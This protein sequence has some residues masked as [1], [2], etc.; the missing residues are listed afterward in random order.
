MKDISSSIN[1]ILYFTKY[2]KAKHT[3]KSNNR[4]HHGIADTVL[5]YSLLGFLYAIPGVNTFAADQVSVEAEHYSN[6]ISRNGHQWIS[7]N[8]LDFSGDGAMI[9]SPEHNVTIRSRYWRSS[10]QLDYQVKLASRGTYYVWVRAY[11][12]NNRSNSMYVGLNGRPIRSSRVISVPVSDSFVWTSG[13]NTRFKIRRAG[14]YTLNLWMRESGTVVDKIILSTDPNFIPTGKESEETS[15]DNFADDSG[16]G[17]NGDA[18]SDSGGDSGGDSEGGLTSAPTKLPKATGHCPEF[19]QGDITFSPKGIRPRQASIW[20][21]P[22]AQT[23]NGPL[24]FYWHGTGMSPTDAI[25][26]LGQKNINE[27]KN[28]GGILV[29]PHSDPSQPYEWF[30]A[31]GDSRLDDVIL[32]D[33]IVACAIEKV[34]IDIRHIHSTG[35]SAGGM[36]TCDLALRRVNYIASTAPQSGGLSPWNLV[37]I[38]V[39][40]GNKPASMIFHG[41]NSDQW[42]TGLN[43]KHISEKFQNEIQKYGGFAFICDHGRGHTAPMDA[44]NSIWQFFRDHPWNM[45]PSPYTKG[46]PAG[47]PKYCSLP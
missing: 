40:S 29:A 21:G 11:G 9:A 37:P 10:P 42:H 22:E 46:F 8:I 43:Y 31:N 26:S 32:T 23:K 41:G 27:I 16:G 19:Y 28:M 47:I 14:E 3:K 5:R 36:I 17:S 15:T 30:I 12:K 18:G 4:D 33:E 25:W 1:P 34:G 6:E 20:I 38:N 44:V 13:H 39:E 7:T 24:V 35:M 2:L 45:S